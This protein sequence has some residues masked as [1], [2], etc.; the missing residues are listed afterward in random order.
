M[1]DINISAG[2]NAN[3]DDFID[4]MAMCFSQQPQ[5]IMVMNFGLLN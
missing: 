5:I 4:L 1:S 3:M 2:E